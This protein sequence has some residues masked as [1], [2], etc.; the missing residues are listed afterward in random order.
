MNGTV[1]DKY[2]SLLATGITRGCYDLSPPAQGC[3]MSPVYVMKSAPFP[4]LYTI[5][6]YSDLRTIVYDKP[7]LSRAG[8]HANH[9]ATTSI[10]PRPAFTPASRGIRAHIKLHP[11]PTAATPIAT[12]LANATPQDP[13]KPTI[14]IRRPAPLPLPVPFPPVTFVEFD[15]GPSDPA[16]RPDAFTD[17]DGPAPPT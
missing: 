17:P 5:R 6:Q 16:T 11:P 10:R 2:P 7:T 13:S 4:H 8:E 15:P 14:S 9:T 12:P 3:T 1:F